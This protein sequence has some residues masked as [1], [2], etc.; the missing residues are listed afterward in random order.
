MNF[1]LIFGGI[2]A[3]AVAA[4]AWTIDGTVT[5][6]SG[7]P[8]AGVNINSFNYAGITTTS[9]AAGK[10]ALSNDEGMGIA[11]FA[12]NQ[13]SVKRDGFTLNIANPSGGSF[14]VSLMDALGKIQMQK[15]FDTK[16]ASIDLK[17]FGHQKLMILKVASNS[18]SENYILNRGAL[19][20]AGDPL[21]SLMFALNGYQNTNYVMK[22]EVETGV[23]VVMAKEGEVP[24][25]SSS[26]ITP[27][28]SSSSVTP[29]PSSSSVEPAVTSC[30][31]KTHQSGD[32]NLS[33][34]VDGK[35]RTFIMHVP[36]A[37]K[38]DKPV[39]LVIDYHPIGGTGNGQLN[40]TTYKAKTDPEGVISFYP[41]GTGGVSP[42]GN[43]WNVG[44]CCSHDDDVAF[45]Y[46]M[47]EYAKQN[48]CIDTKRIYAT[49][50][51]MGG[52]MSN[53]VACM[54]NDVFAAVAPAAM[55]LNINNSTQCK[56]T[57]PISIIMFR[58]TTD[59]IC[60]YAGG[61]S[62]FNDGLNFLGA[63]KNFSFWAD[64]NG[65]TGSPTK[66]SNGCQ[67]YSNCKDGTKVVLCTDYK[68]K[69]S[70]DYGDGETGWNFLKQFTLP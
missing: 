68:G 1:K 58:G 12:Q 55:D 23:V 9:D 60:K 45:S 14:K 49:G 52:G 70:H 27:P 44:P 11:N 32:F 15:T 42:M 36:D 48:L 43:G 13:L 21:A 61:D 5:D 65:C 26:S 53:H 10:F 47:I 63:E 41:D 24:P 17:K 8:L 34:N 22:A 59:F 7:T 56:K 67:E 2:L 4:S 6:K 50:F 64:F 25:K 20:K 57:R 16:N 18:T 30:T 69:N 29:P 3:A 28:P 51:S 31:G 40:G 66:N 39:P 54:M 62:G 33:V 38:G 37:Y 35:N 19:M 46:K